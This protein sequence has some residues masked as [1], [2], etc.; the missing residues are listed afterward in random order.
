MRGDLDSVSSSG[1]CYLPAMG[2]LE[3][4]TR[5][6]GWTSIACRVF[7]ALHEKR[8]P[9]MVAE[10][11]HR[12]LWR[13]FGRPSAPVSPLRRRVVPCAGSRK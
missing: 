7:R 8:L 10:C 3:F 9:G 13:A 1:V 4:D 6:S 11:L 2:D 5:P 12:G